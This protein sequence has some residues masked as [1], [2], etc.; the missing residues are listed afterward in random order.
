MK[1][2]KVIGQ[3]F[4]A[5]VYTCLFTGIMYMLLVLPLS[6]FMTLKIKT[7]ILVGIF[8]GGIIEYV[9]IGLQALLMIPYAWIIKNNIVALVISIGLI[10]FNLIYNDV[11]VWRTTTSYGTEGIVVAVIITLLIA[12][13]ILTS[14]PAIMS[15]YKED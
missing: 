12:Q 6:W 14:I 4:A 3:F 10:L 1:E 8:F 13:T 11:T 15:L 7:M 2:L 9:I 5:I